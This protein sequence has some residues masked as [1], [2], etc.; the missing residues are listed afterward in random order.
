MARGLPRLANG[1]V[2]R[3]LRRIFIRVYGLA[4]WLQLFRFFTARIV[5]GGAGPSGPC[6]ACEESAS[7]T[8]GGNARRRAVSCDIFPFGCASKPR[9]LCRASARPVRPP[10]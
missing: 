4:H 8:Q 1:R 5:L 2:V 6:A 10:G 3:E 9:R 7:I